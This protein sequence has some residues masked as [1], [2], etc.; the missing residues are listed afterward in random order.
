VLQIE[1]YLEGK[2]IL[3][4]ELSCKQISAH[5]EEYHKIRGYLVSRSIFEAGSSETEV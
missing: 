5:I 2:I 1:E 4:T 3:F